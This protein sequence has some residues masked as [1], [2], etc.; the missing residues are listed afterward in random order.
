MGAAGLLPGR[1]SVAVR[2]AMLQAGVIVRA[3]NAMTIAF[4]PPLVIED[5]EIDHCAETLRNVL[6]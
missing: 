1:D 2:D 4:C 3:V 5:A 6:H